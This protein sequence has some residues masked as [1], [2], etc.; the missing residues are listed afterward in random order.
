MTMN[1]SF[2]FVSRIS[3]RYTNNLRLLLLL[4]VLVKYV[5]IFFSQQNEQRLNG[6]TP[7]I[8]ENLT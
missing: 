2:C 8:E 7:T 3:L 5:S 6:I 1:M 4:S